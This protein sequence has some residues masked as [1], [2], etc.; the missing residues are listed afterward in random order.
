MYVERDIESG[1]GGRL[2]IYDKFELR[3]HNLTYEFYIDKEASL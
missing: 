1:F 3:W 2:G